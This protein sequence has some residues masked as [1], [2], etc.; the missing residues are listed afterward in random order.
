MADVPVE[1]NPPSQY[2]QWF[3]RKGS[4]SRKCSGGIILTPKVVVGSLLGLT[5]MPGHY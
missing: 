4:T 5:P 3:G 2:M 1:I